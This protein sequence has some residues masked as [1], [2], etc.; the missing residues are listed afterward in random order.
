VR[1]TKER[2]DPVIL[3]DLK[4]QGMEMEEN[5]SYLKPTPIIDCD[6]RTIKEKADELTKSQKE[7]KEKARTLFY[8][9]RDEI[10]YN[11]YMPRYLPEHFRAS[12]TLVRKNGFCVQKAVLLVALSRAVGIPARIG[13]AVIKNHLMPEKMANMLHGNVL[14]EHGYAELFLNDRWIRV[15]PVFDL[16]MCQK[17]R[18]V[19]V[20][21]DGENDAKFHSQNQDGQLH[22]EYVMDRGPYEDVPLDA[23]REWLIPVLTPKAKALILGSESL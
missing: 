5:K 22:I 15:T 2:N 1:V 12:D 3:T 6:H 21:F 17:N 16:E 9:V 19:P 8:F 20:E 10:K 11:P 7:V 23:I 4:V 14:P 18:I 13:F